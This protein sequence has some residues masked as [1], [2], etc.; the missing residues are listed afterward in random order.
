MKQLI[1]IL[2]LSGILFSCSKS[3]GEDEYYTTT[4]L[5]LDYDS[6]LPIAGAKVYSIMCGPFCPPTDSAV[7]DAA[8]KTSFMFKMDNVQRVFYARK[9][10]Y[11]YQTEIPGIFY[12]NKTDTIYLARPSFVNVTVHKT[13]T[14]LPSD[15]IKVQVYG[16]ALSSTEWGDYRILHFGKADSPDKLYNLEA[17]YSHHPG[18]IPFRHQKIYFIKEIIRNGSVLSSQTD[19]TNII[20]LG[21][22]NFTLNY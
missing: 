15:S 5:V 7:T 10:N 20:H 1:T 11:I 12:I 14:Y 2:I 17:V 19:S 13:G 3:S 6:E 9:N 18:A 22:Q 4:V 8:G 16:D 21:T